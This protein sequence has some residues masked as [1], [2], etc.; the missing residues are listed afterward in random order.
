M[1]DL[2]GC[3]ESKLWLSCLEQVPSLP[4]VGVCAAGAVRYDRWC[5]PGMGAV[6][7]SRWCVPGMGAVRYDR[8]CVPGVGVYK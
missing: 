5:G 3:W 1:F 6:R 8:W 4:A 7:Y 2:C